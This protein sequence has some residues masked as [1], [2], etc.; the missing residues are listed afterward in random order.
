MIVLRK[1]AGL[2]SFANEHGIPEIYKFFDLQ[3]AD[4]IEWSV[5]SNIFEFQFR[6]AFKFLAV[7]LFEHI[8]GTR[9]GTGRK[10]EPV[11]FNL[12]ILFFVHTVKAQ[13]SYI[14]VQLTDRQVGVFDIFLFPYATGKANLL[15]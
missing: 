13:K 10:I 12:L 11:D 2:D 8:P 7:G 14:R 6:A 9:P 1:V 3:V 5:A 15:V 4:K